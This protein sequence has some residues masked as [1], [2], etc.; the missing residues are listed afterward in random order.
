MDGLTA[1]YYV[2]EVYIS[3]S[4][5]SFP[6]QGM[7]INLLA[8]D[9]GSEKCGSGVWSFWLHMAEY[10][11]RKKSSRG[12]LFICIYNTITTPEEWDCFFAMAPVLEVRNS[13]VGVNYFFIRAYLV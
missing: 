4:L 7:I 6:A 9:F 11:V 2:S 8:C 10:L 5:F 3:V 12:E 1:C 13:V